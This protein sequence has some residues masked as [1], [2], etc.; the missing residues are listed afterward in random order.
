MDC[1]DGKIPGEA[2]S[3]ANDLA[4]KEASTESVSEMMEE[5]VTT[6][7]EASHHR[8]LFG[9]SAAGQTD[10]Q[11]QQTGQCQ[12]GVASTETETQQARSVMQS[13]LETILTNAMHEAS[14]DERH[15]ETEI[16]QSSARIILDGDLEELRKEKVQLE[17]ELFI[18]NEKHSSM[19]TKFHQLGETITKQKAELDSLSIDRT[20]RMAVMRELEAERDQLMLAKNESEQKSSMLLLQK[21]DYE[22][23]IERLTHEKCLLAA[24]VQNLKNELE[25][26]ETKN[27][28]MQTQVDEVQ[29]EKRMFQF[30]KDCW[31]QEKEIYLRNREWF[32]NE[33]NERDSKLTLLRIESARITGELEA[34]KAN[35]VDEVETVKESLKKAQSQVSARDEQITKLN[36]RIKEVLEDRAA[37]INKMEEELL[38]AER[39]LSVYKEASED[40]E[41]HLNQLKV[42]YDDQRRLF[43]ESKDAYEGIRSQ[44]ETQEETHAVELRTKDEKIAELNDELLKANDLLKSKHRLTLADD[45]IAALSPSAAAACS[46][47]RSGVSLTAIYREHC[48]VVAE[49]EEVKDEN[50][51][52]EANFRELVEEIER[53]APILTQQR[54]EHERVSEL[55]TRLQ[56]QLQ[57][58]DDER[59]HLISAKDAATRELAYTKAE[60]ERYQR[61]NEDMAR[62]IRHLLHAYEVNRA[63]MGRDTDSPPMSEQD[64]DVLWSSIGELQKVNQK[65]LSDL[66]AVRANNQKAIEE[67]NNTEI[68]RLVEALSEATKKLD[69]MKDYSAKQDVVIEQLKQ[70]RDSY[71]NIAGQRKTEEEVC[72][73][74]GT[75][76][77]E[78]SDA[79]VMI[80]Q[81]KVQSERSEKTLEIYREE[82]H[83]AEKILQDRID[84]QITLISGLR[85]T[86]GKLEADFELQK[87]T[88]EMLKKQSETDEQ[89]LL[90][91]R[92]KNAKLMTDLKVLSERLTLTQQELIASKG[93]IAKFKS[94]VN[95]MRDEVTLLRSTNARLTQELQV[96]RES[97]YNNEKMAFAIQKM[98]N[99]L[100]HSD[101]EK[102]KQ[103]E[104]HLTIAKN[105]NE[106]M[107]KFVAAVTPASHAGGRWFGPGWDQETLLG[108][109]GFDT[110]VCGVALISRSFFFWMTTNKIAT[111]R[112]QALASKKSAEDRL[113]FKENELS[114]LQSKYDE[115]MRQINAP[116]S[117]VD[118]T[119]EG[120]KK[121]A[122]QL[123]NK[124]NYLENQ[125]KDL[126]MKL[127][128]AEK[129][130]TVREKELENFTT[131]SGNLET[132]L[133]EQSA[134]SA[135]ERRSLQSMLDIANEQLEASTA[136]VSQLRGE[137]FKLEQRVSEES[138]RCEQLKMS[139]QKEISEVEKKLSNLEALR[140][141][142]EAR[143]EELRTELDVLKA[144]NK[145]L[146][147]EKGRLRE[148]VHKLEDD[149][150]NVQ[151]KLLIAENARS[152]CEKHVEQAHKTNA[153]EIS[154]LRV[155]KKKLE[156]ELQEAKELN[157]QQTQKIEL[158]ND[159]LMKLSERVAFLERSAEGMSSDS[160][161]RSAS[162]LYDVIKYLQVEHEKESER[163]MNA[164]LQWKRLEA[165]Q[166]AI[167]ERD[168]KLQEEVNAL[169]SKAEESVR[170]IAEKSEVVCRLTM[171]QGVQKENVE[172]KAQLQKYTANVE[173]M[174]KTVNDLKHRLA[175]VEAEKIADKSKLQNTTTDL[176]NAKK[177]AEL[178]KGRHSQAMSAFGKIGPE[179]V[180]NLTSEVET[181]KRRLQAITSERDVAKK[182]VAKLTESVDTSTAAGAALETV[183]NQ[184]QEMTRL[185]NDMHG[186][187]EQAR[188]LARQYRMKYQTLEKEQAELKAQLEAKQSEAPTQSQTTAAPKL[189]T[190]R[191]GWPI[192]QH[193]TSSSQASTQ[194]Q[195][196]ANVLVQTQMKQ[197]ESLN[198][199][200]K[201]L[202]KKM[203]E[204]ASELRETRTKLSDAETQIATLKAETDSKGFCLLTPMIRHSLHNDRKNNEFKFLLPRLHSLTVI[205]ACRFLRR[206]SLET[207]K[208]G[209]EYH[210]SN[211][212]CQKAIFLFAEELHFRLNSITSMA[213]KREAELTKLREEMEAKKA[214]L[215]QSE[216]RVKAL[217]NEMKQCRLQLSEQET[218]AGA[219]SSLQPSTTEAV[220][221]IL[222]EEGVTAKPVSSSTSQPNQPGG[223]ASSAALI[224]S[225]ALSG[226]LISTTGGASSAAV[227][228]APM[229]AS[230]PFSADPSNASESTVSAS[231]PQL[232][233][234][235]ASVAGQSVSTTTEQSSAQVQVAS[236]SESMK[237]DVS[238]TAAGG[239]TVT[240]IF[241]NQHQG[242]VLSGAQQPAT[243][244]AATKTPALFQA[245][246]LDTSAFKSTFT[247][248]SSLV[249][250][251]QSN[252]VSQS[253]T[254]PSAI[255]TSFSG[256]LM[257]SQQQQHKPPPQQNVIS[258]SGDGTNVISSS[259]AGNVAITSG[260]TALPLLGSTSSGIPRKRQQP[261]SD[262]SSSVETGSDIQ[263]P[264]KRQR[265]SPSEQVS[266][267]GRFVQSSS[268]AMRAESKTVHADDDEAEQEQQESVE[269]TTNPEDE[270]VGEDFL[271]EDADVAGE[272]GEDGG[273]AQDHEEEDEDEEDEE[274]EDKLVVEGLEEEAGSGSGDEV[275]VD[276]DVEETLGDAGDEEYEDEMEEDEEYE[277]DEEDEEEQEDDFDEEDISESQSQSRHQ[278][279]RRGAST[280]QHKARMPAAAIAPQQQHHNV[281][282]RRHAD[283]EED[284]DIILI[285]DEE[286]EEG[287]GIEYSYSPAEQSMDEADEG[288]RAVTG[289][290]IGETVTQDD[291]AD[292][293][294]DEPHRAERENEDEDE[295]DERQA[296]RE[297]NQPHNANDDHLELQQASAGASRLQ[298]ALSSSSSSSALQKQSAS[299][300]ENVGAHSGG[301]IAGATQGGSSSIFLHSGEMELSQSLNTVSHT[302][303]VGDESDSRGASST[304]LGSGGISAVDDSSS[305]MVA[306]GGEQILSDGQ[307]GAGIADAVLSGAVHGDEL[308]NDSIGMEGQL[309]GGEQENDGGDHEYHHEGDDAGHDLE[310]TGNEVAEEE[311]TSSK[312]TQPTDDE[313][314][315][316]D[317][318]AAGAAAGTSAT[319]SSSSLTHRRIRIRYPDI[320]EPSSSRFVSFIDTDG[321][322]GAGVRAAGG[323]P[324]M[325]D[326]TRGAGRARGTRRSRGRYI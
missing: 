98:Q 18:L 70:Q 301:T 224:G 266:T 91:Q 218:V 318:T 245:S 62:Q 212:Q 85:K 75:I 27:C 261:Q 190:G 81:L 259:G 287:E 123:R 276:E 262:Q 49:L 105:E 71:K 6:P 31:S 129:K 175:G 24:D 269:T 114:Q 47:I 68:N 76:S 228:S 239:S 30:E 97:S 189:L 136:T 66:R 304:V 268:E 279:Y 277:E 165:L 243:V 179:R 208:V 192:E 251:N 184:L 56:N 180:L 137:V 144:S 315:A 13:S 308:S 203:E 238:A 122:Q 201:E 317:L 95:T 35:V 303:D 117:V 325:R 283:E 237:S 9:T 119:V 233:E 145:S 152:E 249:P 293:S 5:S 299:A 272:G 90:S 296:A 36:D 195:L 312:K 111:E 42:D 281:L 326:S 84:Q 160:S 306:A 33:I 89:E 4:A 244:S 288:T 154:V 316:S 92:E 61:D 207:G 322:Q 148:S 291:D 78:L 206:L 202:S 185:R 232:V 181:L 100:D 217:E 226:A 252:T 34:Q 133:V 40:A 140:I 60:L 55:C 242:L 116:D 25:R 109:W 199:Q 214:E 156:Y 44:M 120:Y 177:E 166:A 37:R 158:L 168:Q 19:Q 112:D 169:R 197:I 183:K 234:Q 193:G 285:D 132:T 254:P 23:R 146:E 274:E 178:W 200:N 186:R 79:R 310:E 167:V 309:E 86:N 2:S 69:T 220:Q 149:C 80:A 15:R 176:Q 58:A 170:A 324:P 101:S 255:S 230:T 323:L 164:E 235:Q 88:Q 99:R 298:S 236:S 173:Q 246:A 196:K 215:E 82:K 96:V 240:S 16:S 213:N 54:V 198:Q 64:R 39:L 131:V 142:G 282:Q 247:S 241:G 26:S 124:N 211:A 87:Q 162:S 113:S 139:A 223:V 57:T 14:G 108:F 289:R 153:D 297:L 231:K 126:T 104:D 172:L 221:H 110:L 1:D 321:P 187:F 290:R 43:D 313:A 257:P 32:T 10:P 103:L 163:T 22:N 295:P 8:S 280:H 127:E 63:S 302:S 171:L 161:S 106:N 182:E 83:Q 260:L 151:S 159:Q 250:A 314:S 263:D 264:V 118:T 275:L 300:V 229:G 21:Q 41:R 135:A 115:L 28:L 11:Q 45:E 121:D 17:Q 147:E 227:V 67:A 155:D 29:K 292:T 12:Q 107:K 59:Q 273:R 225:A 204:L 94:E 210:H 174:T 73:L 141:N 265:A 77:R 130:L 143:S 134:S 48:R 216:K 93:E 72:F 51:K 74:S 125:L 191:T 219:A 3:K 53:K 267:S 320:D 7:S 138:M 102:L 128:A 286:E 20:Q 188:T 50:A 46:L 311:H 253:S 258:G 65:L 319:G 278:L 205:E 38:A 222:T 305:L 294:L 157:K 150:K 270:G 52:L 271:A 256:G 284:D 307:L 194:Q 209:R 248:V